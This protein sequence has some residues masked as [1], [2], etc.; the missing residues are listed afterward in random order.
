MALTGRNRPSQ[1]E[2]HGESLVAVAAGREKMK[3]AA[4]G[5]SLGLGFRASSRIYWLSGLKVR[6][7]ASVLEQTPAGSTR[8]TASS[9]AQKARIPVWFTVVGT[10]TIA[11]P[12]F[13]PPATVPA[14]VLNE[15][16]LFPLLAGLQLLARTESIRQP[17]AV[18]GTQAAPSAPPRL[19]RAGA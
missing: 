17:V 18:L 7:P 11:Y 15:Y 19:T 12:T 16:P 5:R 3:G 9:S 1:V 13:T 6:I 4:V 2:E 14:P 10:P 8:I